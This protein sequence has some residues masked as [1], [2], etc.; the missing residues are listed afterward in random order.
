MPILSKEMSK[1]H[2]KITAKIVENV[3]MYAQFDNLTGWSIAPD[4]SHGMYQSNSQGLRGNENYDMF[5]PFNK[6]R[7]ATFGDSFTHCDDVRNNETWQYFMEQNNPEFQVL[8][9]GVGGYGTDQAYLRYQAIGKKFNADV[10]LIGFMPENIKRHVNVYRAFYGS[11]TSQPLVKPRFKVVDEKLTFIPNPIKRAEDYQALL[12]NT[13][14]MFRLLGAQDY[15][16]QTGYHQGTF[17]FLALVRLSKMI[18]SKVFQAN[19]ISDL[20][21]VYNPNSEAFIV[22]L[23]ILETFYKEVLEDGKIPIIVIL[24]YKE[25]II[26]LSAANAV[27]YQPLLVELNSRNLIYIDALKAFSDVSILQDYQSYFR[28]HYSPKG[29]LLVSQFLAREIKTILQKHP[30]RRVVTA[31]ANSGES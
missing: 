19:G 10:V 3:F 12:E 24:P 20:W 7:I 23:K 21:G 13:E 18:G 2:K 31:I 26:R 4:K 9:F 8:N 1:E 22:T 17:D 29:N 30:V 5:P 14:A 28:T 16:Y 25:D 27:N 11:E 15:Y 6:I